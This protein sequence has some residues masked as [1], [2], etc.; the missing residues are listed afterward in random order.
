MA[1]VVKLLD[2]S[3]PCSGSLAL[4]RTSRPPLR[5]QEVKYKPKKI[6]LLTCRTGRPSKNSE[7]CGRRGRKRK[8]S[9]VFCDLNKYYLI[10]PLKRPKRQRHDRMTLNMEFRGGHWGKGSDKSSLRVEVE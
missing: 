2:L 9:I 3:I 1:V 6:A 4:I 10:A 8:R 7:K 5:K